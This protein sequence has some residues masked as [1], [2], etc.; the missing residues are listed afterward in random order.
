M[1]SKTLLIQNA[2]IKMKND[3]VKF[4]NEFK[5]KK[6]IIKSNNYELRIAIL[7]I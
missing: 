6:Q 1:K 5:A 2:N 4:K 7:F 3:N